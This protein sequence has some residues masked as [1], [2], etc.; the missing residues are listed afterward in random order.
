[1]IPDRPTDPRAGSPAGP[2]LVRTS[3]TVSVAW[4]A[5][6]SIAVVQ[7]AL[8]PLIPGARTDAAPKPEPPVPSIAGAI[9]P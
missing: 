4:L 2:A 8:R 1:M 5:V 6:G 9:T 7:L 3:P